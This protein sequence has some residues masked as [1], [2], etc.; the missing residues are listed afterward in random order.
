MLFFI[1]AQNSG[2]SEDKY[3]NNKRKNRVGELTSA[4]TISIQSRYEIKSSADTAI[5]PLL[6][7]RKI[8]NNLLI[9]L[10]HEVCSPLAAIFR[11]DNH[12]DAGTGK[13]TILVEKF[14][15]NAD[16]DSKN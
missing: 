12:R 2:I 1:S 4:A 6:K 15:I 7:F 14:F 16:K 9:L 11:P 8:K 13:K 5:E 3:P 10:I